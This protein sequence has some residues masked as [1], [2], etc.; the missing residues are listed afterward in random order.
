MK[1][2]FQQEK[3]GCAIASL[4]AITEVSYDGLSDEPRGLAYSMGIYAYNPGLWSETYHIRLLLTQLRI[5][6]D[7]RE[8]A[9]A[10]L[11]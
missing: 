4:A 5:R 3:T 9:L 10:R 7:S 2:V 8:V 1:Q 6:T 11:E